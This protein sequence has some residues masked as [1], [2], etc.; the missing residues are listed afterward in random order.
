MIGIIIYFLG[1]LIS[2]FVC[3]IL[4]LWHGNVGDED[5]AA[6]ACCVIW[7][8]AAPIFISVKLGVAVRNGDISRLIEKIRGN[9]H[10]D[11]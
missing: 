10:E 11:E 1:F 6:F 4:D 2:I 5:I 7:V 3:T 9:N 8:I